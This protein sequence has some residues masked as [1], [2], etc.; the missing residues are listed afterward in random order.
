MIPAAADSSYFS[1]PELHLETV[2]CTRLGTAWNGIRLNGYYWRLYR[3]DSGGAGVFLRGRKVELRPDCLYLLPPNCN[4][5]T[6]NVGTPL[7]VYLHFELTGVVGSGVRLLNELPLEGGLRE[8]YLELER[9]LT[10]AGADFFRRSFLA[11]ALAS[12]AAAKLPGDAFCEITSDSRIV[13]LCSMM[14][15]KLALPLDVEAMGRSIGLSE[16]AFLRLFREQTGVT[17]YQYLLHLRYSRAAH[18]LVSGHSTI[19]DIC[20]AVGVRDRFHFSRTFKKLHGTSPAEYR[21]N[22]IGIMK[23]SREEKENGAE[24]Q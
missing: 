19:D 15:E 12:A 8:L 2:T 10:S 23:R 17:P 6:W 4:L 14:R 3:N 16:N 7:Q 9:N 18:L 11:S 5:L 20:E 21:K 1:F 24:Q 13:E 22:A